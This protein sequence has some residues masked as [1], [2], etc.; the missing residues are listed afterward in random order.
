MKNEYE[1]KKKIFESH[2]TELINHVEERLHE[3]PKSEF[4]KSMGARIIA[5]IETLNGTQFDSARLEIWEKGV[6]TMQVNTMSPEIVIW[7]ESA[8][9]A[10]WRS[11]IDV[12][13]AKHEN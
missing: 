1:E 9:D 2:L 4:G 3:D 7:L 12:V 10:H 6:G 5:L 8:M 11:N 13:L